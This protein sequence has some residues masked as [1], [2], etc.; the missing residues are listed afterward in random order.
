M[1]R[2][3]RI[4]LVLHLF[5]G[6]G[7][8][9]GGL[10]AILDPLEP[11]GVPLEL[12]EHSSFDDY[13]IPGLILFTVIGVGH[14][15]SA[16]SVFLWPG[17]RGYVSSVFSWALMIFIVVQCII[18]RAVNILHVIFF[19]IGLYGAVLAALIL[20]EK[21]QFPAGLILDRLKRKEAANE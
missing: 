12:L 1:E 9:G 10:A 16:L 15:F 17:Y 19:L 11:A 21:R 20:F 13:L 14:I 7:A 8:L 6:I 4:L 3:H 18:L 2:K 5:V